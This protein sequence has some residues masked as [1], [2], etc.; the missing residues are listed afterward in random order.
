MPT[1]TDRPTPTETMTNSRDVLDDLRPPDF[2]PAAI[3]ASIL[4]ILAGLVVP[5]LRT[6]EMDSAEARTRSDLIA[7]RRAIRDFV[8]DVGLP[9]TR[10]KA[11]HDR[12]LLRLRGPG[13]IPEGAYY[14]GDSQQG[15]YIDH[16]FRNEPLGQG[17]PGYDGWHGPYLRRIDYDPWGGAY[18]VVAYPLNSPDGR[19]CIV[20][21]AGPNGRMDADYSSPRDPVAAGDD[22]LEIVPA[23]PTHGDR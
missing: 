11:G 1:P 9:P 7:I 22:I 19:Q 2:V 10:D 8:R 18:I 15:D 5:F 16:L 6:C 14:L 23:A 21:S 3:I 4:I 20:I 12:A 13:A 17:K